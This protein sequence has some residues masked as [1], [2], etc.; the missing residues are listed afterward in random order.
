M[1]IRFTVISRDC[2][3]KVMR[4]P[5]R[6]DEKFFWRELPAVIGDVQTTCCNF[7]SDGNK[8]DLF[9][10]GKLPIRSAF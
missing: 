5:W 9:D 1:S 4:F 8:V 3:I 6:P 2:L 7:V 10:D